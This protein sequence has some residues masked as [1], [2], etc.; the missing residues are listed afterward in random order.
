MIGSYQG[1]YFLNVYGLIR[2]AN[3]VKI[4]Y[5]TSF[6]TSNLCTLFVM[7]ESGYAAPSISALIFLDKIVCVCVCVS[8]FVNVCYFTV[9]LCKQVHV[10]FSDIVIIA[11]GIYINYC[12]SRATNLLVFQI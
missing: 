10:E 8:V 2:T 4:I 12:L 5:F 3:T 11:I 1:C 9:N 6:S 7:G